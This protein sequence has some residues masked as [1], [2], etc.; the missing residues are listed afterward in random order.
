MKQYAIITKDDFDR[1]WLP[2]GSSYNTYEE[3]YNEV[4]G[5][6]KD[7]H[8]YREFSIMDMGNAHI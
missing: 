6:M 3:A 7:M 1:A 5:I 4:T 8:P 2:T